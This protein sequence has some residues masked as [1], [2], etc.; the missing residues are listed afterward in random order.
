[1]EALRAMFRVSERFACRVVGQHRSTQRYSGKVVDIEEVMLRCSVAL[2]GLRQETGH[3]A[4]SSD[5]RC[6]QKGGS[7][8]QLEL[9]TLH[10]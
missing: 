1:M 10:T 3:L 8:Q 2:H 4:G 6:S 9:Q 7:E 5:A